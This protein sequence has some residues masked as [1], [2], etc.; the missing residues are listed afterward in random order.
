MKRALAVMAV[1]AGAA[2]LSA[3]DWTR[4]RGP[5][6]TGVVADPTPVK[7]DLKSDLTWKAEVPGVGYGSPIVAKG[8]VFLQSAADTGTKRHLTCVDAVS[9]KVDWTATVDAPA[10]AKM[11]KKNSAASGTPCSDGERVYAAFWKGDAVA[12]H[13]F[14]F[15]GKPAWDTPLGK[16]TSEHGAAHSPMVYDGKV[17]FNFDQDGAAE[18]VALDAKTGKVAWRKARRANRSCYTTP[19]VLEEKG[20]PAQLIVGSTTGVTGYDPKSGDVVWHYALKRTD[21]GKDLRSIGQQ[22]IAGGNVV[23]YCGEG[24]ADRYMVAVK[25]GGK[26][27]IS[28]T[29]KSWDLGKGKTPYVPSMLAHGDHLYWITDAGLA[30]CADAKTGKVLWSGEKV[31]EKAVSA[32]PIL[33]GDTILAVDEAGT[34]VSFKASPKG[35]GDV[36]KS[37]LGQPVL[38]SPAAANGRLYLRGGKFLYCIGGKTS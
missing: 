31:F 17:Y 4:F 36:E 29:G 38:A 37:Q 13:A 27:D 11:H 34:V 21:G 23:T 30:G 24:G 1:A 14:D 25:L 3:A 15:Q 32:S 26:G 18:L 35:V 7:F 16:F 10:Q 22:V 5:N 8:K 9:G 2:A 20:Q 33:I 28:A 6:G 19:F 12:I